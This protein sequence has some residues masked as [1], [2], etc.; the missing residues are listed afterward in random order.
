M[1]NTI[2][3]KTKKLMEDKHRKGNKLSNILR[4]IK[5]RYKGNA[6]LFLKKRKKKFRKEIKKINKKI[7]KSKSNKVLKSTLHME[8]VIND[9]NVKVD[10]FFWKM[11]DK[12]SNVK[13][14]Y[15]QSLRN[16]KNDKV[17]ATTTKE[18]ANARHLHFIKDPKKEMIMNPTSFKWNTKKTNNTTYCKNHIEFTTTN[19]YHNNVDRVASVSS[20]MTSVSSIA[21]MS[22]LTMASIRK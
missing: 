21:S 19:N 15:I 9:P 22:N 10:K 1:V 2:S 17:V 8:A 18:I 4:K 5:K 20:N 12:I 7:N 3:I 11:V 6:P 13:D 14:N 16:E